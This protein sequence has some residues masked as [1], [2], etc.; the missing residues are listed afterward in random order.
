[1]KSKT[2]EAILQQIPKGKMGKIP[3]L[4]ELEK[5]S[6]I[7]YIQRKHKKGQKTN[8]TINRRTDENKKTTIYITKN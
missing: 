1:M 2:I 7:N 8:Y 5:K 3:N 6:L 4:K